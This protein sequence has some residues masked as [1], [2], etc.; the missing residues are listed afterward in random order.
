VHTNLAIVS[1]PIFVLLFFDTFCSITIEVL[2][3]VSLIL[4]CMCRAVAVG[5]VS[6]QLFKGET[7]KRDVLFCYDLE[8]PI[9]FQPR[10]KGFPSP[11]P[12]AEC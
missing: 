7:C 10:N 1:L 5:A 2:I 9:D 6:Y 3:E 8:L 12:V 11:T 4:H